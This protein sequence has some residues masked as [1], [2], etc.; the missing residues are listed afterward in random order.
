M[1]AARTIRHQVLSSGVALFH[2]RQRLLLT[3]ADGDFVCI[4]GKSARGSEHTLSCTKF[5]KT[6]T[7]NAVAKELS[8]C[9]LEL[10]L[11]VT[12]NLKQFRAAHDKD[13]G[14]SREAPDILID[15]RTRIAIDTTVPHAASSNAINH[16]GASRYGG[17]AVCHA[18][19]EKCSQ[20]DAMCTSKGYRFVPIA[21]DACGRTGPKT[22]AWMTE[23]ATEQLMDAKRG[24]RWRATTTMRLQKAIMEHHGLLGHRAFL[25]QLQASARGRQ[26]CA[27][28]APQPEQPP[29]APEID[30]SLF[31][32]GDFE[33]TKAES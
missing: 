31:I 25:L 26:R 13:G 6:P 2:A 10:G 29:E 14:S 28:A 11:P 8:L 3:S 5:S 32:S 17:A 15:A 20:N 23:F 33:D 30:E 4:C 19:K 12:T 7:H 22:K 24:E 1:C 18:E 21:I 9:V 27:P 16:H